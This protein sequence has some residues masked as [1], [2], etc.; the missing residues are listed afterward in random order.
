MMMWS[1]TAMP[2]G[3]AGLDDRLGHV[4]V[5]ARRRR[6]ARRVVVDEDDRGGRQFQR[7]LDHLARIDR[8]VVDRAGL[9]HFVGDQGVLLVEEQDAELLAL[10][11]GHRRAAI[12]EHLVPGGQHLAALDLAARHAL[13]GGGDDLEVERRAVAD[14]LDLLQQVLRRARAL[15]R[16]S[17]TA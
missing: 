9:L 14:V 13:R 3:L 2:S 4:D 7:A 8:R 1:C 16:A 11:E 6:I 10:L 5:G 17:R 12:V 15:R